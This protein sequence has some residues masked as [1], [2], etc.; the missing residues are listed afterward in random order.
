MPDVPLVSVVVPVK[1]RRERMLRCLRALLSQEHDSYEVIV[2]DNGSSDGTPE[3]CREL[4]ADAPVAVRVERLDGSLGRVR[5]HGAALARGRIL[6]FTDSDCVPDPR[7]LAEGVAALEARAARGIVCG[8]TVPEEPG[9]PDRW[10]PRTIAVDRMTWRFEACNVFYRAEAL[11]PTGGFDETAGE[12]WE[13]AP[14]GYRALEAGWEAAFAP[15]A[16]VVHDVTYPGFSWFIRREQRQRR[17]ASV[18]RR[19]PEAR[20]RL[21]WRGVFFSFHQA[22]FYAA[23]GGLL[24]GRRVPAARLLAVPYAAEVVRQTR[25]PR[26][27]AHRV[28]Y[29]AAMAVAVLR[30][31]LRERVA[32]L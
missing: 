24:L 32:V 16:V 4:A 28:V 22:L 30:G 25:P 8:R 26:W 1:D 13:D 5:N 19:H 20:R 10:W 31:A 27:I 15:G 23:A 2:V 6:A 3:A 29:D 7:W 14:A 9:R 12:A 17:L 21:L 18:V 11:L